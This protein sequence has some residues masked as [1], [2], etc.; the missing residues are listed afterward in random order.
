MG[1]GRL[2]VFLALLASIFA[3]A[4][5]ANALPSTASHAASSSDFDDAPPPFSYDRGGRTLRAVP[6]N[7]LDVH[8]TYVADAGSGHIDATAEVRFVVERPGRPYFELYPPATALALDGRRL[9]PATLRRVRPTQPERVDPKVA[10]LDLDKELV[11]RSRPYVLRLAY[12]VPPSF[13]DFAQRGIELVFHM[14]DTSRCKKKCSANTVFFADRYFPS[15]FEFDT[16]AL[17]LDLTLKDDSERSYALFSNATTSTFDPDRRRWRLQF[18]SWFNTASFYLHLTANA[19]AQTFPAS[20]GPEAETYLPAIEI[21][22]SRRR[23]ARHRPSIADIHAKVEAA[24]RGL[25]KHLGPFP[26]DRL[27]VDVGPRKAGTSRGMEY[28]GA[29]WL[30][31]GA[32]DDR[33]RHE[34]AHQWLGRSA[35][36]PTA[37]DGWIDEGLASLLETETPAALSYGCAIPDKLDAVGPFSRHTPESAY[38][39][40]G[41]AMKKLRHDL[42]AQR[43]DVLLKRL[44]QTHHHGFLTRCHLYEAIRD[45]A[46]ADADTVLAPVDSCLDAPLRTSCQ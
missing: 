6:V 38:S 33:L 34:V 23:A 11:P 4:L 24:I 1:S 2:H 40:G 43:H 15:N 9:E 36:P 25:S 37:T 3:A 16:F 42:G 20:S 8:V 28:A 41:L 7:I 31:L 5:L 26:F 39:M 14:S 22:V 32:S 18:P 29:L 19:D 30:P 35:R 27:V 12:R 46:G 13:D 17:K 44:A 10:L 45:V 21:H